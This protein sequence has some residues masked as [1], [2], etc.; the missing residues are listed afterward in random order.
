MSGDSRQDRGG[1]GPAW[2]V[3]ARAAIGWREGDALEPVLE[4]L[5]LSAA[6]EVTGDLA[7]MPPSLR[8]GLRRVGQRA[9]LHL[10]A[11]VG[12]A[13]AGSSGEDGSR[14]EGLR[15]AAVLARDGLRALGRL[16]REREVAGDPPSPR[17]LARL[18]AGTAEPFEAAAIARRARASDQARRE[19]AWALRM[20]R[21]EE[22]VAVRLAAAD[23]EPM[24]DPSAGRRLATIREGAEGDAIAEVFAFGGG[25]L[26]VYAASGEPVRLEAPG[27][28]TDAMQAGYWAG[29]REAGR[30]EEPG[31][32]PSAIEGTLHVGTRR[33]VV[34]V[35]VD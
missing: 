2:E 7:E 4:A 8:D 28:R 1:L 32:G 5:A 18:I 31:A 26:A 14:E 16:A 22:Q 10:S 15:M 13:P 20:R 23:G 17:D 24:R 30:V 25:A 29:S 35:T 12:G 11:A 27:V 3:R 34:S 21:G 9:M 19:L 33:F 6:L